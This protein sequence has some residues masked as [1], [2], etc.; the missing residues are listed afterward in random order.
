MKKIIKEFKEK[1]CDYAMAIATQAEIEAETAYGQ[2]SII[3]ASD[4]I[5]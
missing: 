4:E 2:L 1:G 5:K 3:V